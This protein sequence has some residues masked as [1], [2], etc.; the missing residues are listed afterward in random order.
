MQKIDF[1][2]DNS[3]NLDHE[4]MLDY[5]LAWTLRS[6]QDKNEDIAVKLESRKVL[7]YLIFGRQ[8][9]FKTI[10]VKTWKQWRQIDLCVEVV[11]A[12]DDEPAQ[13]YAILFENKMYTHLRS[14]QLKRYR[15][16]FDDFYRNEKS[17][18]ERKYI[19]LTCF[20]EE[21]DCKADFE[22]CKQVG[23]TPLSFG[24]IKTNSGIKATGNYM[25]DEFWFYYW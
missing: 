13:K 8:E 2:R 14:N 21:D 23:F 5:F 18:F 3:E 12:R 10:D 9:V 16:I 19:F 15:E 4:L 17:E 24:W 6:A 25:F 22:E 1:F 11:I 7:S 20:N